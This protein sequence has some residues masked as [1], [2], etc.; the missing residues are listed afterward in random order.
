[1]SKGY[2]SYIIYISSKRRSKDSLK[3]TKTAKI[4][5]I[6]AK[7]F[8]KLVEGA[9]GPSVHYSAVLEYVFGQLIYLFFKENV[10]VAPE[11]I[12]HVVNIHTFVSNHSSKKV[13]FLHDTV[14]LLLSF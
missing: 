6:F 12:H 10:L 11:G 13:K 9:G 3:H 5:Y 14:Y 8:Q 2:L 4:L 7:L 1:M